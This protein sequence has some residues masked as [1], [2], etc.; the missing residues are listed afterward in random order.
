MKTAYLDCF[1]GISGDMFI[2]ALLDAGLPFEELEKN[3]RTLPLNAYSLEARL[4]ERNKIFGARFIVGTEAQKE[5]PRNLETIRGIIRQG[6]LSDSVKKRSIEVFEEI[7]RIEG[8]IHNQAPDQVHFHEIGGIDS[9][10]D[11]V[12]TLFGIEYL[13]ID[14]ISASRLPLGSG[15][16]E[17]AHGRIPIPAPATIAL[18]KGVPVFDPG[19][20]HE[21]VTPTGAAL[22]KN[23]ASYFGPMPP[24]VVEKIG[25]GTGKR[26]LPDRPNMLRILIGD[27]QSEQQIETVVVLE[28]NLDDTSPELLGY[29]MER[30]FEAGALDVAF[31]P[32]TMKK[33]RPGIQV[34]VIAGPDQK[35]PLM[36]IIFRESTALGIRFQYTQRRVLERSP[37]EV[38]SPWG[39]I[40]VKKVMGTEGSPCF[41][42]EYEA[43]KAIAQKN[44]LPLKEIYSWVMSLNKG[45]N[46][47]T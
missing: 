5:T 32:V 1:S 35:D 24:M 45:S 33:N 13:G 23:L 6:K 3:L 38:D 46:V 37:V 21:L 9:I 29:I 20:A 42:P 2:G 10:I 4:E 12:G 8:K 16:A 31:S 11:I 15:F 30:L 25:Y 19:I 27:G 28:T 22:V 43:C 36:E 40:M 18:L 44:K 17:T 39:K 26:E 41:M 14:K 47:T 34:Q 7:A